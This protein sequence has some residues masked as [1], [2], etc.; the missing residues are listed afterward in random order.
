[1]KITTLA[2]DERPVSAQMNMLMQC[3][4]LHARLASCVLQRHHLVEKNSKVWK[5]NNNNSNSGNNNSGN[6]NSGN[7][8]TKER[9]K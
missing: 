5:N 7:R 6:N 8:N 2:A 1:M 4:Q 3:L 9:N